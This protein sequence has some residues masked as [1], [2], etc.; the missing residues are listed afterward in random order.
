MILVESNF[1]VMTEAST[2]NKK[3]Y[4]KGTFM[5]SETPNRNG[6]SYKR[7]EISVAVD[8]INEAARNGKYILGQCDHP[9][10]LQITLENVSHK[11]VEA[12]MVNNIAMGKAEILTA[13]PKGQIV[14]GLI[15]SGIQLGVSSRGSG[16][17]NESTGIVEG[18]DFITVDVVATP[19]ANAYPQSV[20]EA[21]EMYKRGYVIEDLAESVIHDQ[22]AQKY[23]ESEIK[24]FLAT[25]K[26]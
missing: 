10:D 2:D 23:F 6:R 8:K 14:A 9:N 16:A 19:S 3:L 26:G 11:L 5:E 22:K 17:V 13:T 12:Q 7:D 15:E 20:M 25:F 1:N 4:L 18:F 21:L 24:K